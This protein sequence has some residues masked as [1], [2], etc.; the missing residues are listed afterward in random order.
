MLQNF[1]PDHQNRP[2]QLSKSLNLQS[3]PHYMYRLLCFFQSPQTLF[4]SM[5]FISYVGIYLGTCLV[6]TQLKTLLGLISSSH[7]QVNFT[8][9]HSIIS[10][11]YT[12]DI[13]TQY[14]LQYL[15]QVKVSFMVLVCLNSTISKA[16]YPR[17]NL[18]YI[19][20]ITAP[21]ITICDQVCENRSYLHIQLL[22]FIHSYLHFQIW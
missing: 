13:C 16:T 5:V 8:L 20:S 2:T 19:V 11:I 4:V 6:V 17:P 9:I 18:P 3:F 12:Q 14:C 7:L 22:V 1:A 10:Y 21:K 15:L